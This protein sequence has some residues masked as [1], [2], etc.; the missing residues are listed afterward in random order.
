MSLNVGDIN[1]TVCHYSNNPEIHTVWKIAGK[2]HRSDGTEVFIKLSGIFIV[3]ILI[4]NM[5]HIISFEMD[6]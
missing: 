2:T 5:F 3:T 4:V 6:F 1:N